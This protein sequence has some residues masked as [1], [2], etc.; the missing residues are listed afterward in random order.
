MRKKLEL[1]PKVINLCAIFLL[2]VVAFSMNL[3]VT[4]RSGDKI[5]VE[6]ANFILQWLVEEKTG[7]DPYGNP[8]YKKIEKRKVADSLKLLPLNERFRLLYQPEPDAKMQ[9]LES[10]EFCLRDAS[11]I[12]VGDDEGCVV[13]LKDG[14]KVWG[15]LDCSPYP[16]PSGIYYWQIRGTDRASRT[17]LSNGATPGEIAEYYKK[18]AI[19]Y[20]YTPGWSE[21]ILI[22]IP[23]DCTREL[24]PK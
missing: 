22:N 14:A 18:L 8:I 17:L 7:Y 12:W 11:K 10:F 6:D 4:L 16:F 24:E 20:Q 23:F 3:L 21:V 19:G 9:I 15:W 13:T 2:P 1:I 5:Y